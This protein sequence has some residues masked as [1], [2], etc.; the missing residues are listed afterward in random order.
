[1][2]LIYKAVVIPS[3]T[4][5]Y[6]YQLHNYIHA[7][8]LHIKTMPLPFIQTHAC[9]SCYDCSMQAL[10]SQ[11]STAILYRTEAIYVTYVAIC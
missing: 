1:M 7:I 2:P 3:Y 4:K 10:P 11:L 5:V 8:L 6:T 9:I